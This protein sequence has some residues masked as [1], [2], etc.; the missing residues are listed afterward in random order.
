MD[1]IYVIIIAILFIFAIA[2]LIVGVSNDAVNFLVSAVG[3]KA[4]KFGMIMIMAT[5]GILIGSVFSD[6]MMEV[7][8]KGIFNPEMFFFQ[9]IIFLFLA[10]MLTDIILLDFF[11]TFGFPTSTTVSLVFELLGAAV[12]ISLMKVWV[13]FNG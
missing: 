10:V 7:A 6:G 3:S 8:R 13:S 2:D 12:G 4:G 1:Q 9:E 5:L 11:N